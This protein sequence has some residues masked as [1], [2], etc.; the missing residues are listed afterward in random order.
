MTRHVSGIG[1]A[2]V[3]GDTVPDVWY[4]APGLGEGE[5]V[6]RVEFT[7]G[8]NCVIEAGLYLTAGTKVMVTEGPQALPR[9]NA[10]V[11]LNPDQHG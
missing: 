9:P 1:L 4:P 3:A 2:T 8:D 11:A 7:P 5:A 10:R 6:R